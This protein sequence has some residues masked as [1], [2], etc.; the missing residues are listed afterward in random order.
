[1]FKCQHNYTWIHRVAVTSQ[2][3]HRQTQ[4]VT[5]LALGE[6]NLLACLYLN[7]LTYTWKLVHYKKQT[8]NYSPLL[9]NSGPKMNGYDTTHLFY[10]LSLCYCDNLM[11]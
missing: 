2:C 7:L 5:L 6:T 8:L 4:A 10:Y 11:Q 3:L 9:L 1:M